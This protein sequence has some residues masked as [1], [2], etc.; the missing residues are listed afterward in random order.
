MISQDTANYSAAPQNVNS[1]WALT[2]VFLGCLKYACNLETAVDLMTEHKN[3]TLL[4][5]L[6]P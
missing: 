1:V 2:F 5:P 4:K 3:Y 6:K